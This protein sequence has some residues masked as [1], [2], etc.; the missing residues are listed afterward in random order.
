MQ[1]G[2]VIYMENSCELLRPPIFWTSM[3]KHKTIG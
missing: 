2:Y 3:T 1:W